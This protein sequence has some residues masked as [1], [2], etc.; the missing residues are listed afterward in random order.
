MKVDIIPVGNSRG[1]RIPKALLEQCGFDDTAE[2]SLANGR[3]ILC[4]TTE[5]RKGWDEAF[6]RMADCND[7]RLLETPIPSFD[8]SEWTW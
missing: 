5:K 8:E 7:D 3:L 6:Q 4:P 1:I 2:L